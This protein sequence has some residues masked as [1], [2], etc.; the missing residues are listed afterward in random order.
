MVTTVPKRE[1]I[2]KMVAD[3]ELKK[4]G[5]WARGRGPTALL[6]RLIE[7]EEAQ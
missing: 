5:K 6:R 3:E 1:A 4:G 7:L 2:Q